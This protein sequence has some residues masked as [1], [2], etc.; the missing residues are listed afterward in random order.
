MKT[1]PSKGEVWSDVHLKCSLLLCLVGEQ[2]RGVLAA[3]VGRAG[4]KGRCKKCSGSLIGAEC[5]R[6]HGSDGQ[7]LHLGCGQASFNSDVNKG[8]SMHC[9]TLLEGVRVLAHLCRS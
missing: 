4:M 2:T 6:W 1:L 8:V 3:G 5:W 7:N 9:G